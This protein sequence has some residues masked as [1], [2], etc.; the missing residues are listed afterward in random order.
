MEG[1]MRHF[2][3]FGLLALAIAL[4]ARRVLV[5][6]PPAVLIAPVRIALGLA[7]PGNAAGRRAVDGAVIAGRAHH[8][9]GLAM[10]AGKDPADHRH[11]KKPRSGVDL[12]T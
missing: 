6:A 10:L 12:T 4:L 1:V 11:R 7:P 2:L 8:R 9:L 5:P 3:W